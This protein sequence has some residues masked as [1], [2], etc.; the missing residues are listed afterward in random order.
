MTK[1]PDD[2]QADAERR[3][4][5]AMN[6]QPPE[7]PKHVPMELPERIELRDLFAAAALSG[8]IAPGDNQNKQELCKM[9]FRY[10]DAMLLARK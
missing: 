7:L 8:L 5:N 9:A 3:A 1:K 6:A 2:A 4:F 10:A